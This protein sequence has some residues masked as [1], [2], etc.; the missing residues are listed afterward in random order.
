MFMIILKMCS[1]G[2]SLAFK[3]ASRSFSHRF[4][5]QYGNVV[6]NYEQWKEDKADREQSD[7]FR[8]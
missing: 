3:R 4:D 6:E 5:Y 8:E 2:H 7:R 1:Y